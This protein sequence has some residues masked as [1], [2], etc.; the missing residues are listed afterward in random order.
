M[1]GSL[2]FSPRLRLGGQLAPK[3]PL[4]QEADSVG[5]GWLCVT[6]CLKNGT[7]IAK[8]SVFQHDRALL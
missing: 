5:I 7:D 4:L 2:L 8:L 1:V 3:D 6:T